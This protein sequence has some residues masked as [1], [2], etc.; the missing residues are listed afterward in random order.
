MLGD[1]VWLRVRLTVH[2]TDSTRSAGCRNYRATVLKEGNANMFVV[3]FG[4]HEQQLDKSWFLD[5]SFASELLASSKCLRGSISPF[6]PQIY[7]R[8]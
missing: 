2:I 3:M 4:L 8:Y 1:Q 6:M 5:C 7:G